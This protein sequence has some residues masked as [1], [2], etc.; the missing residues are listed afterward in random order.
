[1]FVQAIQA[2][3]EQSR[4]ENSANKRFIFERLQNH[5]KPLGSGCA[6]SS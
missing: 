3:I 1:M 5:L 6:A 4:V 2:L